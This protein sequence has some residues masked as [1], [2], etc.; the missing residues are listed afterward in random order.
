MRHLLHAAC[1]LWHDQSGQFAILMVT[2][3]VVVFGALALAVDYSE[4]SRRRKEMHSALDAAALATGREMIKVSDPAKLNVYASE[5]F[6]QNLPTVPM[7]DVA[8][9]LTLPTKG[10]EPVRLCAKLV[11][12]PLILP[13]VNRM[14]GRIGKAFE[15]S[16][17]SGVA[18]R[19]TIEVALVLD[20]SG[21]MSDSGSGTGKKRMD[22]LKA[23]ATQLIDTLAHEG[24]GLKQIAE[25]VRV[26]LVPFSATVN[27]GPLN[28]DKPWLDPFGL[29]PIHHEFFD[30]QGVKNGSLGSNKKVEFLN[31]GWVKR[32]SGWG[33]N[34][35]GKAV[36][37]LTLFDAMK[38]TP[39]AGCVEAR[40]WPYN[41]NDAAAD[42]RRPELMFVP[43]FGPDD[44]DPR[45]DYHPSNSYLSDPKTQRDVTKFFGAKPSRNTY[46]EGP[47]YSCS[48]A[49]ITPLTDITTLQGK[50]SIK[51]AI[52]AMSPTSN[53]DVPEGLAWGWR[54]LS[55]GEPFTE[56][57]P[58][59][60]L[61]NDKVVIVLTDGANTYGTDYAA[62][63]TIYQP[64]KGTNG[65]RLSYGT[66]AHGAEALNQHFANLCN[67][68]R[69]PRSATDKRP[70]LIV[71]TVG[72]DLNSQAAAGKNQI[73]LLEDCAS[74]SRIDPKRKLF[75]N[76]TG[77]TLSATFK[78]IADELS[79]LRVVH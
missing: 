44:P 59:E 36:T 32:G 21:S 72:L 13:V 65:P 4:L 76:A 68:I 66:T 28:R 2:G 61:G 38:S 50:T 11:Y 31:G 63:G 6:H 51:A 40:P 23:A 56:G 70:N 67:N 9:T 5:F 64:Y 55:N 37:R 26:A 35:D 71:M 47:N 74:N 75:W 43:S 14:L 53:T 10:G 24:D 62:Y 8:L 78:D 60:E 52:N 22:L 1:R 69:Q 34:Q 25:P 54:V 39:W 58:D 12:Q 42:S 7:K 27:V 49:P 48:T 57:R 73:K 18:T 77:A 29:S 41:I 79:N 15:I 3:L 20:N 45:W 17:C 16:T 30:W 33:P 46:Y 19:N